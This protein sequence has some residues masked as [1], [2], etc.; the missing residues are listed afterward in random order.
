M[1]SGNKYVRMDAGVNKIA[2]WNNA[3]LQKWTTFANAR[4]VPPGDFYAP[5]TTAQKQA[6]SD[7]LDGLDQ[8]YAQRMKTLVTALGYSKP[9]AF[10]TLWR[11]ER[12]LKLNATLNSHIEDHLYPDP[13]VVNATDDWLRTLT[14]AAVAGKPFF[15][16]EVNQR[17]SSSY[18]ATDD[19]RRTMFPATLSTYGAL[20][21]WA[22]FA[23]F[24]MNHGDAQIRYDG[25]GQA[26]ARVQNFGTLANDQ[27]LLNHMKTGSRIFR[28]GLF[29][30]SGSPL[31]LW[32]DDP[33]WQ[34]TYSGL[35]AQKY[36]YQ[37]GWQSID[38]IRK[39]FGTKPASQ[40]TAPF[41]TTVPAGNPLVSDT[42]QIRK[43]TVRKQLT[44]AASQ[45]EV[46]SGY[47][48]SVQ[49]A[50]LQRLKI[51]TT[52]GFATAMLVAEDQVTLTTSRHLLLSRTH[53]NSAGAD[54]VGPAI[55]LSGLRAPTGTEFWRFTADG[56]SQTLTMS[57]G[58]LVLPTTGSWR[59]AE[60]RLMP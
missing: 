6:R 60:L 32:V 35:V 45:A 25:L 56:A 10:S 55:T 59:E 39:A 12:P 29:A 47:L 41:M 15:L 49:P 8:A 20:H 40:A 22:G 38:E 42:G 51:N 52:S 43:D 27:M 44:G 46:F 19:P 37:A 26:P 24:A 9:V 16:G 3:L 2:Y 23:W 53:I 34:S 57:S 13:Y 28:R 18:F 50:G 1:Y 17:E 31:T 30:R 21:G 4:A 58:N 48:D 54:A 33:I 7:F 5:S 14:R 11:G 36:T